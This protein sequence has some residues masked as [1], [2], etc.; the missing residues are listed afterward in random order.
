[1]LVQTKKVVVTFYTTASAME[2]ERACKRNGLAGRLMP[3][4]RELSSDCGI[5]W[6]SPDSLRQDVE[7][8]IAAEGI[9]IDGV[10]EM[11]C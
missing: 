8:L 1:M 2:M 10:F 3:V 9:E 7:N 11:L 6:A 4:P 5:A